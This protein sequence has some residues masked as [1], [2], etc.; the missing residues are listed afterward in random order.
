MICQSLGV[1]WY[2]RH[3]QE[4]HPWY[5][6][7]YVSDDDN[8]WKY[9]HWSVLHALL[10]PIFCDVWNV[11]FLSIFL[12]GVKMKLLTSYY[13]LNTSLVIDPLL[14]GKVKP[15]LPRTKIF[16]FFICWWNIGIFFWPGILNSKQTRKIFPLPKVE[17]ILV[18]GIWGFGI[19][20]WYLLFPLVTWYTSLVKY[21]TQITN[22]SFAALRESTQTALLPRNVL[23]FD[24]KF[25]C[26]FLIWARR[27]VFRFRSQNCAPKQNHNT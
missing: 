3:P 26:R 17:E 2:P 24:G 18:A 6:I 5:L 7:E 1:P 20:S 27:Y 9:I 14:K 25:W 15:Q 13:L 11:L 12:A 8:L 10:L 21:L 23:W 4:R 22:L 19:W 16:A